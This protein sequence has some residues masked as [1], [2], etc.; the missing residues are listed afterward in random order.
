MI[1]KNKVVSV[2]YEL[3]TEANGEVREKG[4]AEKPLT[5]ICGQG[6]VLEYFELNLLEKNKG[7]KFDFVIANEHAYGPFNED[8][9]VELPLEVFKDVRSEDLVVGND[10][11]MVDSMGRHLMG[12][13]NAISD[14]FVE[15]N[16]NHPLA[17]KDLHF[18][19]EILELRDVT[20]A[21]LE[22]LNSHKCGG[23]C[24]SCSG[25][26]SHDEEEDHGCGCGSHDGGCC[27]SDDNESGCCGGGCC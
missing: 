18:S 2:S 7:D 24:S 26:G 8:M 4:T 20:D 25:C 19:G 10:L 16:F 1:T 22:A 14:D 3:R 5:F 12:T 6:Q 13:I 23:G 27:S 21:E 11:P 15:I 9:V 17:G